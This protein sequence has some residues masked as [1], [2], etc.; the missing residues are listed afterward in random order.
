M[1]PCQSVHADIHVRCASVAA[2]ISSTNGPDVETWLARYRQAYATCRSQ[3][4]A[5]NAEQANV[6]KPGT[7]KIAT[8]S[9]NTKAVF[10]NPK[11]KP[12]TLLENNPS[13]KVSKVK[14]ALPKPT[15]KRRKLAKSKAAKKVEGLRV[16]TPLKLPAPASNS[17][18][19]P[20]ATR[21]IGAES[22][23]INCSARFGGFSK[24][25]EWY[26]SS[27]GKRVSCVIRE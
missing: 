16:G 13:Q 25:S 2:N 18:R 21:S 27:S 9:A 4:E 26:I 23:R 5:T 19:T 20:K 1:V 3:H 24:N 10:K 22:W 8:K 11:Y 12:G 17:T 15:Q 14:T 6:A 7:E